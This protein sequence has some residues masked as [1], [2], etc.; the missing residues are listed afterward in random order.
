MRSRR[1]LT[2][3]TRQLHP[4]QRAIREVGA[5]SARIPSS[6]TDTAFTLVCFT[7]RIIASRVVSRTDEGLLLALQPQ[8]TPCSCALHRHLLPRSPTLELPAERP[9]PSP[10]VALRRRAQLASGPPKAPAQRVEEP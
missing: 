8:D 4:E 3:R 6:S 7:P 5:T 10:A 2:C 9:P 1:S